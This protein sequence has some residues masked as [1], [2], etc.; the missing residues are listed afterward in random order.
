MESAR[1]VQRPGNGEAIERIGPSVLSRVTL[2]GQT[3]AFADTLYTIAL[4]T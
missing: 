3:G 4:S 2:K 1:T